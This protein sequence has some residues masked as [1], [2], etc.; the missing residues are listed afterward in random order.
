MQEATALS[1]K[2]ARRARRVRPT[3]YTR[4]PRDGMTRL[5]PLLPVAMRTGDWDAVLR[6]L[7]DSRP[8]A[9]LENL[10][11]LAGQLK[12]VRHGYAGGTGWR[13]CGC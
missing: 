11:F 10:N 13:Y 2:L 9:K 5:D 8:E 12:A 7:K 3:L 1:A 4:V 6:M